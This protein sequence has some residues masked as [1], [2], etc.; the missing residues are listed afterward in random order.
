MPLRLPL[1]KRKKQKPSSMGFIAAVDPQIRS[2]ERA[3]EKNPQPAVLSPGTVLVFNNGQALL[4]KTRPAYQEETHNERNGT[5]S[6]KWKF[7]IIVIFT[8][9]ELATI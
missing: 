1:L 8:S 2:R 4:K 6:P 9:E 5:N 7:P 3:M